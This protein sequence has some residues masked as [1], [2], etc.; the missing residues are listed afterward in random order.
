MLKTV[1][2]LMPLVGYFFGFI[3]ALWVTDEY[4]GL[5]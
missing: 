2:G 5:K 3:L 4:F 1:P